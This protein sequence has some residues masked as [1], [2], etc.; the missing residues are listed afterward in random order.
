MQDSKPHSFFKSVQFNIGN[1]NYQI[2]DYKQAGQ[3][4][5][6]T[7][8]FTYVSD[9]T[10]WGKTN[11]LIGHHRIMDVNQIVCTHNKDTNIDIM[12]REEQQMIYL[13]VQVNCASMAQ[14]NEVIHQIKRFLPVQKFI[15]FFPFETFMALPPLYFDGFYNNPDKHHIENLFLRYDGTTGEKNYFYKVHY[16]PMVQ[17][18][19]VSADFSDNSARSYPVTCDFSYLIQSPIWL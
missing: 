4:E 10:A 7:G 18:N 14:A 9:E 8:I 17:L 6:P 16:K 11:D 12:C 1:R 2:G 5:F 19:N 15:Q 13:T 3:L